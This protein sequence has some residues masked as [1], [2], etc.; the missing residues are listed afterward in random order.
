M[1]FAEAIDPIDRREFLERY[2]SQRWLLTIGARDRYEAVLPW[3]LLNDTL[4]R[5]RS[6]GNRL[7]LVRDG[8]AIEPARYST[9]DDKYGLLLKTGPFHACL[10]DGATLVCDAVDELFPEVRELAET[11][12]AAV[13]CNVQVNLY[14]GWRT[15]K[16][17]DLH[18]DAH[19]TLIVQVWGRKRWAVY[20]PTRAH[21]LRGDIVQAPKP[22]EPPV[23]DGVLESGSFLYMPRG[24][25][26]VATPLDEPTLHLT[27][28]MVQ[29]SGEQVLSW[30]ARE[31]Q[32]HETFR[33]DVPRLASADDRARYVARMRELIDAM[34][35]EDAV[36]RFGEYWGTELRTRP[37]IDLPDGPR[38]QRTMV[39]A[40]AAVQLSDGQQLSY[41]IEPGSQKVTIQIGDGRWTCAPALLPA[42]RLLATRDERRVSELC[43]AIEADRHQSLR[44][45]L[46]ALTASGAA[47]TR[48][49]VTAPAADGDGVGVS[50]APSPRDREDV[51]VP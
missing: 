14:A 5:M 40:G 10:A 7:R 33:Q 17:F 19:D 50:H 1:T 30:L 41:A 38:R 26:H 34:W 27:V 42:L 31:L 37:S 4:S 49:P 29:P 47:V 48:T 46:T 25:W 44:M 15:Q 12:Q 20:R 39:D 11:A 22:S 3:A 45:L 16:G 23:W 51:R 28:A 32:V 36:D 6:C 24:W 43:A 21:P 13:R 18:W 8:R 2:L 35:S 9:S